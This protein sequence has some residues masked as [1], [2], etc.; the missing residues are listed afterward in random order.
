MLIS[1]SVDLINIRRHPV[2]LPSSSI[3]TAEDSLRPSKRIT[4]AIM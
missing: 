3:S 1:L 2:D 4:E